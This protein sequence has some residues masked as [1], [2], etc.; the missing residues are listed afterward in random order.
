MKKYFFSKVI[1]LALVFAALAYA[2]HEHRSRLRISANV[3]PKCKE[4]LFP[5]FHNDTVDV[6]II[7][8]YKDA[9]PA[10]F[11][12][13]RYE[14]LVLIN[15]LTGPCLPKRFDCEFERA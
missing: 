3:P 7:F 14:R 10:R 2:V 5:I 12:G 8:G 11:V 13:D 9:R 4:E 1:A 15:G 6:R